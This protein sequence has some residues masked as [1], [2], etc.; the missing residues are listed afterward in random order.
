[1]Q[2]R[3]GA[4]IQIPCLT[5]K[6]IDITLLYKSVQWYNIYNIITY[7]QESYLNQY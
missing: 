1:M 4:K 3:I 5:L 6:P 7:Y 2:N